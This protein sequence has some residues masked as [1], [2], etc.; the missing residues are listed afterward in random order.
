MSR[1][2]TCQDVD[3]IDTDPADITDVAPLPVDGFCD[4]IQQ[5]TTVM[6]TSRRPVTLNYVAAGC[7]QPTFPMSLA[8]L[9]ERLWVS[10]SQADKDHVTPLVERAAVPVTWVDDDDPST[11]LPTMGNLL[12]AARATA[13]RN[14]ATG[15]L[16]AH[17]QSRWIMDGSLA[18]LPSDTRLVGVV[19]THTARFLTNEAVLYTLPFRHRSPIFTFTHPSRAGSPVEPQPVFSAYVRVSDVSAGPWDAGL[20]RV[21]TFDAA[22]IDPACALLVHTIQSSAAAAYDGR[23]DRHLEPIAWCEKVLRQ[24]RPIVF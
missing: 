5:A 4:G 16:D 6:W 2:T 8:G 12:S 7:V 23:W 22:L 17:P 15:L 3:L 18:L 24:R 11:L 20:L 1:S 10:A 14:L 19:K 13:E 9:S 21:E